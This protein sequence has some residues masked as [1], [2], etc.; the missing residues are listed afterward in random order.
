MCLW[1]HITAELDVHIS[2]ASLGSPESLADTHTCKK[3]K[4]TQLHTALGAINTLWD[5]VTLIESSTH[6]HTN[7]RSPHSRLPNTN[8]PR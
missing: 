1:S 4:H 7:M 8:M 2:L 6:T 3:Y 5:E